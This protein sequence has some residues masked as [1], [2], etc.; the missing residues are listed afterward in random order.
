MPFSFISRLA[1]VTPTLLPPPVRLP[2]EERYAKDYHKIHRD[3]SKFYTKSGC[4]NTP[5]LFRVYFNKQIGRIYHHGY[6]DKYNVTDILHSKYLSL[7][8]TA[9]SSRSRPQSHRHPRLSAVPS[10]RWPTNWKYL[11]GDSGDNKYKDNLDKYTMGTTKTCKPGWWWEQKTS[12]NPNK[13]YIIALVHNNLCA[14][15]I[16]NTEHG[17]QN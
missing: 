4:Q 16:D 2:A 15:Q 8:W 3:L 10:R 5:T 11:W 7:C 9:R 13:F 17:A 12:W 1:P 6:H 14:M